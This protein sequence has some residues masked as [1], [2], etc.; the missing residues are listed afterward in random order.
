MT[1]RLLILVSPANALTSSA[2]T[3][4]VFK[5]FTE[6]LHSIAASQIYLWNI[7][8]MATVLFSFGHESG[9]I[10]SSSNKC[11]HNDGRVQNIILTSLFVIV[12]SSLLVP[13]IQELLICLYV[14]SNCA[15]KQ[16]TGRYFIDNKLEYEYVRLG[17]NIFVLLVITLSLFDVIEFQ[18]NGNY[19][20]AIFC[21][22]CF[23]L[24][25][26]ILREKLFEIKM[27]IS[28]VLT[29]LNYYLIS[30]ATLVFSYLDTIVYSIINNSGE[31]DNDYIVITFFLKV[32]TMLSII[33]SSIFR[34][35]QRNLTNI[36][37]DSKLKYFKK[38]KQIEKNVIIF[39][40]LFAVLLTLFCIQYRTFIINEY[41]GIGSLGSNFLDVFPILFYV[42]VNR[43]LFCDLSLLN[44]AFSKFTRFK[45]V[46]SSGLIGIFCAFLMIKYDF[47]FLHVFG[48]SYVIQYTT[49]RL[50]LHLL[51]WRTHSLFMLSGILHTFCSLIIYF[52]AIVWLA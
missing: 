50:V 38:I 36:W 18:E 21:A 27:N 13:G 29:D 5:Y 47:D 33:T 41:L 22:P 1:K 4:T 32:G 19:L 10:N 51:C 49:Y 30:L 35:Y 20:D 24:A 14:I 6:N 43:G 52:A 39:A 25:Y 40:W 26:I 12:I 34:I 7:C 11:L 17:I 23:G 16:I 28:L 46:I 42:I 44:L 8:L 45:V 37:E 15:L 48:I 2:V 31:Q 3:L 9:I